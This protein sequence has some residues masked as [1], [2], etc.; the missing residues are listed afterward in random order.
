MFMKF[1]LYI[2]FAFC[3]FNASFCLANT[4]QN[5]TLNTTKKGYFQAVKRDR[6]QITGSS[7]VYPFVATVAETF[8]RETGFKTPVVEAVGTGGGF[9]VFCEGVGHNFPDFTNASRVILP[10]EAEECQKNN[11][12]FAEI[13]LGYDGI[14]VANTLKSQVFSLSKH[15]LF[16]ALASYVPSPDG[17]QLIT[18]NYKTW[19]QINKNLPDL[20]II[21]YGP[22][23]SSGTRDSF[24]EL[25]L[26]EVCLQNALFIKTYP[27]NKIRKK[28]CA[29]I[30]LDGA[31][32]EAG[33]NDNLIVQKLLNN[34]N[35]FGIFGFS[36][37]EENKH[38]LQPVKI[39]N[40]SPSFANITNKSYSISR[41]LFIYAKLNQINSMGIAEFI[42]EIT[43][44]HTIG[45][46]GYLLQKGLVPLSYNELIEE[47]S[48][49][50]KILGN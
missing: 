16:L 14:V 9:K 4:K 48:K 24:I 33:E 5:S 50:A 36:F 20:P 30:R 35:A 25:V 22:P 44:T 31:F 17:S 18:N 29:Q 43:S 6:L 3:S 19:Q 13:K 26:E 2:I 45:S 32:I 1:L 27:D 49:I 38:L 46:D 23:S 42:K 12:S 8:G 40:I 39:N 10:S 11:I 41:P 28:K 7:T 21:I 47:R 15:D 37:L 34:Q